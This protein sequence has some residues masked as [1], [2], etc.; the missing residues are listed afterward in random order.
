M[1]VCIECK[2]KP[3]PLSE[4]YPKKNRADGYQQRCKQCMRRYQKEHY[5]GNK[6][7]YRAIKR[8]GIQR[9]RRYIYDYML[10][11]PCITCGETNPVLL[12]FDHQRDKLMSVSSI[13][14]YGLPRTIAEIAKCQ[15][16]CVKC[17]R[18]KTA[19]DFGWYDWVVE[20]VGVE[21]TTSSLKV[22]SATSCATTPLNL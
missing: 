8:V 17:H 2:G 5:R 3:Q 13:Y 22:R 18:L 21:P 4:F 11:H 16:L 12:E 15:V 1:K 10:T 14:K 6:D 7:R 20:P 9:A 19:R